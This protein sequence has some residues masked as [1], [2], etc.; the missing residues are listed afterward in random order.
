MFDFGDAESYIYEKTVEREA[1]YI[2]TAEEGETYT[3][4][5]FIF[6]YMRQGN[7]EY[8]EGLPVNAGTYNVTIV[9]PADNDYTKFEYTYEGVI[10]INRA[11]RELGVVEV[12][13]VDVG[14]TFLEL[15][16]VGDGGIDD[17]SDEAAFRYCAVEYDGQWMGNPIY[18]ESSESRIYNLLPERTYAITV[19]VTGDPNYE[20]AASET[21]VLI[22]T[23]E[24][25][26]MTDSWIY[27][28]NY[29]ISWYNDTDR[30]FVLS[31]AEEL[32]GLSWLVGT[33]KDSFD[34]KTITLAADID[35]RGH[36]WYEIGPTSGHPFQGVFDGGNHKIS[37]LYRSMNTDCVGLFGYV[38]DTAI[39]NVLLD[40]AYISGHRYVG[41]IAGF[42]KEVTINNCVSYA[43]V[44]A[45][46]NGEN[47]DVGGIVG[48]ASAFSDFI[49]VKNCV[50]YGI[51]TGKANHAGGIVGYVA[52]GTVQSNANF[53]AVSGVSC[54]AGIVGENHG[55]YANGNILLDALNA[56]VTDPDNNKAVYDSLWVAGGP[57][58]YPVPEGIPSR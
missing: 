2:F 57:A 25:P 16:V 29:D 30:S 37:G 31:T 34:G 10:T 43:R 3:E 56:W 22:S 18:S 35:L 38:S 26:D 17:L 33:G 54:V 4:E 48:Y 12:E 5:G 13:A 8:E 9:R 1:E 44:I 42:T 40:D 24:V 46:G 14:Y 52:S 58:G 36:E 28:D 41:G 27:N 32:A 39:K 15:A 21:G 45:S 7:T 20:D 51:V 6:K 11:L 55:K 23:L 53:G 47:A 49:V 19:T 50:I